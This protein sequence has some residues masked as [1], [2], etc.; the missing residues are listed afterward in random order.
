M[1][2]DR[3]P[4]VLHDEAP[5]NIVDHKFTPRGEWWSLCTQCGYG[6]AAHKDTTVDNHVEVA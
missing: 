5:S 2:T 6:E 3:P 4:E 1:S